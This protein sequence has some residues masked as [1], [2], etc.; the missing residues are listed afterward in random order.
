M[1]ALHLGEPPH[2]PEPADADTAPAAGRWSKGLVDAVRFKISETRSKRDADDVD[3]PPVPTPGLTFEPVREPTPAPA[4]SGSED[5]VPDAADHLD[6]ADVAHTGPN[7]VDRQDARAL[8]AEAAAE[9]AEPRLPLAGIALRR[10]RGDEAPFASLQPDVERQIRSRIDAGTAPHPYSELPWSDERDGRERDVDDDGDIRTL[11]VST[12]PEAV[13]AS[14][15]PA[16]V[17]TWK[18]VRDW[19]LIIGCAIAAALALQTWAVQMFEIPSESMYPTLKV[20]DRVAVNKAAFKLGSIEHGQLVVFQRPKAAVNNDASQPAQLIKRVIG[21]PGD[22]VEARGGIVYIDGEPIDE[23]AYLSP[24][25]ITN[26]LAQPVTVAPGQIFVMGDN[27]EHSM[28]SREF[29]TVSESSV[30]GRA[31]VIVWPIGRW[32]GFPG[33]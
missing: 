1:A 21:L 14:P 9:T 11:D 24:D 23:S 33:D 20:G 8:S 28:D 16:T 32:G 15:A 3:G 26:N 6:S 2:H 5:V 30:I 18:Q 10:E 4:A 7:P 27:R 29:G 25:V 31:V 19:V 13:D 17:S 22:V 12:L